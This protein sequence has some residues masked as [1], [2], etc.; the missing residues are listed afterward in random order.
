[1]RCLSCRFTLTC[2][3]EILGIITIKILYLTDFP[4]REKQITQT[5]GLRLIYILERKR[6]CLQMGSSRFQFN[7]HIEK[8]QKSRKT[9]MHSSRMRTVCCSG[10]LG[11]RIPGRST[12]G[13][14]CLGGRCVHPLDPEADTLL[15]CLQ[16]DRRL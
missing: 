1:M 3:T 12:L 14:V 11:G 6:Y 4:Y 7:I 5:S 15:P 2:K 8:R 10:R 16:N 13:C 9:R